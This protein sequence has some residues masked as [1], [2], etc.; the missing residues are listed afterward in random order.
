MNPKDTLADRRPEAVSPESSPCCHPQPEPEPAPPSCCGGHDPAAAAVY[1]TEAMAG[2]EFTCPMHPEVQQLGPGTCPDCGMALEPAEITAEEPPNP[3]L[4]DFGRRLWVAAPATA[5]LVAGVMGDMLF[6]FGLAEGL[7]A[8]FPWLQLL[9]AT[10]VVL[11][12]GLPFF[13]RAW[14]SLRNRRPNMFTLIGLG[15]GA[16]YLYSLVATAAPGLIP[17]VVRDAAGGV[18]LYFEA[19]AVIVTL[20][21][22][23]QVLELR[24]RARTSRS[25]RELLEL[26]PAVALRVEDGGDRNLPLDQVRPGDL[27]RVR[28]GDRIPVDG[29]VVE[30]SSA[31]D[32]SMLTGEPVPASKTVGEAVAGGTLNGR[33]ALV[34]RAERVGRDTLLAQIVQL[35]AKAQRSRAPAQRL[36]DAVAAVFVPVVIAVAAATFGLWLTFGPEPRGTHALVAAVAVLII[37]CP[38]VLGLATPMSIMVALGRG[39]R[40]GVLVRDAESLERLEKVDTLV[41]DKTGTLTEGRPVVES[42]VP[43]GLGSSRLLQL[44]ASLER[45]SGHPLA[46]AILDAAKQRDMELLAVRDFEAVPGLGVSG[47]VEG[48]PVVLGNAKLMERQGVD[49]EAARPRAEAHGRRGQTLVYVA[50]GGE[51]VGLLGIS[52]PIADGAAEAVGA[53]RSEGLE[54]VMATGDAEAA[55]RRVA[56]ELGIDRV[57]AGMLPEDKQRLI[58]RLQDADGRV[59]MAGDGVNDAPALAQADV[60]IAMGTGSDVAIESAGVTLVGG[61]LRA[62]VRARRL[63]RA[64]LRNIRQNLVFA[65]GYNALGIPLA[66]G[67]LYPLFG[68]LL[69]PM[70]AAAA[71]SLSSVSVITNALR[72]RNLRL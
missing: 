68:M 21:L 10:P 3:E 17:A 24:A 9:L 41:V 51:L 28:P 50:V 62:L 61:D 72:L 45:S 29:T 47:S 34:M 4:E 59:A 33:G 27:L 32:E 53:L 38:C 39:A 31:V 46:E 69:S 70:V 65:F 23:G 14:D 60:G 49:L 67:A 15:T 37:A 8:A 64:T 2:I 19:A 6:G 16:A 12:A 7:G 25:L 44:A 54:I 43:V 30:G 66:A 55:A 58:Q 11:W 35:V 36:A 20:V 18:A 56:E 52:D 22:V 57:A 40:A 1:D 5:V 13:E 48:S 71:M 42:I 26:A 63:S